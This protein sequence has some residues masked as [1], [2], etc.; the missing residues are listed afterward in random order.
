MSN[1]PD[2][3]YQGAMALLSQ[4][5]PDLQGRFGEELLSK[6]A[7]TDLEGV[8]RAHADLA[9]EKMVQKMD[10]FVSCA[11]DIDNNIEVARRL[12]TEI[13]SPK[14]QAALAKRIADHL[15]VTPNEDA[16]SWLSGLDEQQVRS[17]ALEYVSEKW[18]LSQPETML[19]YLAAQG[20]ATPATYEI[21]AKAMASEDPVFVLD[22][23]KGLDAK[24][25]NLVVEEAM[26]T[27]VSHRPVAATEWLQKLAGD[28][29]R[30][31]A[32]ILG[33]AKHADAPHFRGLIESFDEGIRAELE[34]RSEQ[35]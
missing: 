24:S 5:E 4:Q 17:Q 35:R 13:E 25:S 33:Y 2:D 7:R 20:E 9:P 16:I 8:F 30:R 1:W 32:A 12:L 23:S 31:E 34:E 10:G 6:W 11:L 21:F 22:W 19:E 15:F 18:A 14:V 28:D 26:N 29:P 3:D 27:W